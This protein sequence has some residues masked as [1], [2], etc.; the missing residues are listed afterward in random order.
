MPPQIPGAREARPREGGGPGRKTRGPDFRQR[1]PPGGGPARAPASLTPPR[2]QPAG[3]R[4]PMERF[5]DLLSPLWLA[6]RHGM[7]QLVLGSRPELPNLAEH[8]L[9]VSGLALGW[10][11]VDGIGRFVDLN[12]PG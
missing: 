11:E 12:L 5:P 2:I 6:R 10:H 9:F 1:P 4:Q 8:E 3:V 7:P